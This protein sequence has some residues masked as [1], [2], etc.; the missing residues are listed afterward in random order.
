MIK[1]AGLF[2]GELIIGISYGTFDA[3]TVAYTLNVR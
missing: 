2:S 1:L 3:A